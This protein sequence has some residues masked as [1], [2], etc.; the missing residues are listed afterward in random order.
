MAYKLIRHPSRPR[1][2]ALSAGGRKGALIVL[3]AALVGLLLSAA[4]FDNLFLIFLKIG[5][6]LYGGGYVLLAFL[7]SEFVGRLGWLT[8]QQLLDAVAIG[9]FTPGPLFTSATFVGYILQGVPGA[10]LAT[11]GIF[12]PA[13]MFVFLVNPFIPRLR[14]SVGL[15]ALLDGVNVAALGLMAAVAGQLAQAALTD[16]LTLALAAGAAVLLIRFKINSTWLIL[17]GALIGLLAGR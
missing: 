8:Q 9:Q 7:R 13:F 3:L 11:V 4:A 17:G 10:L 2:F 15:G 1:T 5:S 6:V 14:R 16:A 12:L